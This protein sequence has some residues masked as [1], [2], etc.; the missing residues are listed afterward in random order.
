MAFF[1]SFTSSIQARFSEE[2][3]GFGDIYSRRARRDIVRSAQAGA[4]AAQAACR[5]RVLARDVMSRAVMASPR[6]L[7]GDALDAALESGAEAVLVLVEGVM[8]GLASTND[9]ASLDRSAPLARAMTPCERAVSAEAT[10]AEAADLLRESG[11]PCLAVSARG[12][13]IVGIVTPRELKIAG[14]PEEDLDAAPV[15][16]EEIGVGD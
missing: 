14:V 5:S 3:R 12:S 15:P 7:V 1:T 16:E 11:L 6:A 4:R 13:R 2:L 9:L 8:A 10:I